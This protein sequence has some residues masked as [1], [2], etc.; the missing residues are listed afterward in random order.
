MH[1]QQQIHDHAYHPFVSVRSATYPQPQHHNVV[2]SDCSTPSPPPYGTATAPFF[3]PHHVGPDGIEPLSPTVKYEYPDAP[4]YSRHQ[5]SHEHPGAVT[6]GPANGLLSA[7]A[8]VPSSM[9]VSAAPTATSAPSPTR[10]TTA[11]TTPATTTAALT[12]PMV[13]EPTTTAPSSSSSSSSTSGSDGSASAFQD[14]LPYSTATAYRHH[15]H[16]QGYQHQQHHHQGH[17]M[18]GEWYGQGQGY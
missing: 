14:S 7:P 6:T 9:Q 12:D 15:A 11:P 16:Q 4:L 18:Q 3:A 1:E 17:P 5:H 8:P 10:A 2:L 13:A